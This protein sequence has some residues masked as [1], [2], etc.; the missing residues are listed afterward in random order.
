MKKIVLK[1]DGMHCA[2]CS[3]T[4]ERAVNKLEGVDFC[5]VNLAGA[6]ALVSYDESL[7]TVE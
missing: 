5:S 2:A 4:V 6:N 7:V 3:A 1:V